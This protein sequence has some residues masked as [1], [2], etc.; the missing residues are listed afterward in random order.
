MVKHIPLSD[1]THALLKRYATKQGRFLSHI[2]ENI[3]R[4]FLETR[5]DEVESEGEMTIE[6]DAKKPKTIVQ[7][8]KG[9]E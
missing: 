7:I 8:L 9:E 2:G 5:H 3:I 4:N 6:Q 1:E